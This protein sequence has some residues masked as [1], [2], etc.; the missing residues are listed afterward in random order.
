[1]CH[2]SGLIKGVCTISVTLR[3]WGYFFPVFSSSGA[4][5]IVS[6][7]FSFLLCLLAL[8]VL[9]SVLVWCFD[10]HNSIE[11]AFLWA[12]ERER[13]RERDGGGARKLEE[14]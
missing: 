8:F 3:C 11:L 5:S 12:R 14:F 4:K 6:S 1:M 10:L 9:S 13:V 7:S 2:R